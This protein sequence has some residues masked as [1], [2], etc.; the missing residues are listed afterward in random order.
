MKTLVATLILSSFIYADSPET[1]V[2]QAAP[3]PIVETALLEETPKVLPNTFT[4]SLSTLEQT[5]PSPPVLPLPSKSS[6]FSVTLSAIIPGLGNAY[7]GDYRTAGGIFGSYGALVGA[8]SLQKGSDISAAMVAQNT[9][10]YGIYAAY[11]DTRIYNGNRGY[12]YRMPTDTFSDVALAPFRWSVL[13][14]VEVWGGLLGFLYLGSAVSRFAF[15]PD[16]YIPC[17][18][19]PTMHPLSAFSIGVGE[20]VF[21]R[22]YLQSVFSEFFT[23]VGGIILSSLTFGAAH[24]GN[25]MQFEPEHRWRYYAFG[26][27]F[28]TSVGGYLGWLSYKNNSLKEGI[29]LHSWYDFTLFLAKSLVTPSA[30]S[31]TPKFALSLSF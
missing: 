27:P 15:S 30:I 19:S 26:L 5:P 31:R 21:F 4:N 3:E 9:W 11:R 20:E 24:L 28:I 12:S 8:Q 22:G 2:E 23:P 1:P 7:L 13:K 18:T 6:F 17:A 14:K 10:F 25:A 16:M 29:A